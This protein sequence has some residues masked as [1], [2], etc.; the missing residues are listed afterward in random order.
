MALRIEKRIGAIL[1]L[2][3][4]M[5]WAQPFS[6]TVRHEHLHGGVTGTVRVTADSIAFEEQ[7]KHTAHSREWKFS[8][9]QQLSLSATQLR[10][11]TYEDRK[12]QLGL[13]REYVFDR[14]PE[15]LVSELYPLFAKTLDQRFVAGLA[16]EGVHP[17]WQMG[18]KLRGTQ[19]TLMVGEDRI[20]YQTSARGESRTWRFE[21]IE[22]ISTGGLFD[23]S[24]TTLERSGWRQ[25]GST[26]F[27]FELKEALHED[28]YNQLWRRLNE[29]HILAR[30]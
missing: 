9:I 26:E 13:D 25:A 11:L 20:V 30:E 8:D 27:H 21:D 14:L 18:A 29:S 19:G 22:S 12:W 10:V 23:F 28:R 2:A 16:D 5:A 15:G 3:A 6:Y 7:G 17:L 1:I 24:I 4:S